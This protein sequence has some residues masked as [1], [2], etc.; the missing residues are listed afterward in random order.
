MICNNPDGKKNTK[1]TPNKPWK[2]NYPI[3]ERAGLMPNAH[4]HPPLARSETE[5]A[6]GQ[7]KPTWRRPINEHTDFR[8]NKDFR[9]FLRLHRCLRTIYGRIFPMTT[10]CYCPSFS[11]AP[12]T[13]EVNKLNH[14]E[15]EITPAHTV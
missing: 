14:K 6:S 11:C 10:C 7:I 5:F 15:T 8:T 2:L 13:E 4:I 1:R 12:Q 9:L 3:D